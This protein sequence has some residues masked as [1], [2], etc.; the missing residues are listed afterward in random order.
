MQDWDRPMTQ[1]RRKTR[2]PNFYVTFTIVSIVIGA[3]RGHLSNAP[4][5]TGAGALR[6]AATGAAICLAISAVELFVFDGRFAAHLRRLP[7]SFEFALRAAIYVVLILAGLSIVPALFSGGSLAAPRAQEVWLA[8]ALSI[9]FNAVVGMNQLLGQN[10][11]FSFVAGR[12]HRPKI[13]ERIVLFLDMESSTRLAEY[14]GEVRF[15]DLLNRFI[16]DVTSAIV[17]EGGEIHK[18]V[19]DEIIATWKPA[20]AVANLRCLTACFDAM[21]TLEA[22]L[23]DY[24]T[25][26]DVA[27]RFRAGLHIGQVVVGEL[28]LFKMEIALLGDT[29]NTTARIQAACRETGHR[30]LASSALL[31]RMSPL[32]NDIVSVTLGQVKLRGKEADLELLAFEQKTK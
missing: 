1:A 13:E 8:M 10:V 31:E 26:F 19:G 20:G 32:P 16:A 29:M 25:E 5:Q 27:V 17:A 14:L 23:P 7:F 15:L 21:R 2:V 24:K 4:D 6:G 12:Y 9:A 11:L 30:I 28:G 3:V 18:Y 22:K